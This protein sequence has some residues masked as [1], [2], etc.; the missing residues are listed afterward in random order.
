MLFPRE[1]SGRRR[2]LWLCFFCCSRCCWRKEIISFA[3]RLRDLILYSWGTL[4]LLMVMVL[5]LYMG[6]TWWDGGRNEGCRGSGEGWQGDVGIDIR[7]RGRGRENEYIS[8]SHYHHPSAGVKRKSPERTPIFICSY[9]INISGTM[10]MMMITQ[11][12]RIP[13]PW[14]AL[15]CEPFLC[16]LCP[17]FLWNDN[18]ER[19][20]WNN[21]N[22]LWSD[23]RKDF[24][25]LM[26]Y[27]GKTLWQNILM[28]N[29]WTFGEN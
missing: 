21:W 22:C 8:H 14:T 26:K 24:E 25:L 2:S 18:F 27:F 17:R 20:L 12:Y 19:I 29:T 28:A 9:F 15:F 1:E 23:H 10:L 6:W 4:M 5:F 13:F 3:H 16:P 11:S 7:R